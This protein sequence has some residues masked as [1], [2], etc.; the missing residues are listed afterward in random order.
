MGHLTAGHTD[1]MAALQTSVLQCHTQ[2]PSSGHMDSSHWATPGKDVPNLLA[3][4]H[5]LV[6]GCSRLKLAVCQVVEA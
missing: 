4:R 6:P 3:S 2:E 1:K 5:R